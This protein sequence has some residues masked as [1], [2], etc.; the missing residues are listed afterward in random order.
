MSHIGVEFCIDG[1]YSVILRLVFVTL[2]YGTGM[3]LMYPIALMTCITIYLVDRYC[4]LY[5]HPKPPE[6]DYKLN[7]NA[8]SI[9]T[10]A[11]L[12]GFGFGYWM[13]SNQ[14]IFYNRIAPI[15]NILDIPETFHVIFKDIALDQ[16]FPYFVMFWVTILMYAIPYLFKSCFATTK[17]KVKRLEEGLE[18]Y[19]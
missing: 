5:L 13:L 6:Y 18:P 16:S 7:H 11:P 15:N 10:H 1:R 14:Q 8:L 12:F 3:P 17:I 9:L 2:M 19:W 4:L